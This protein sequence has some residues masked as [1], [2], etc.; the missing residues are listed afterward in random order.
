MWVCYRVCGRMWVRVWVHVW[1]RVRVGA[2]LCVDLF[3]RL[4]AYV[5]ACVAR[6]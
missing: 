6:M 4:L 5:G 2:F 3:V 1:V